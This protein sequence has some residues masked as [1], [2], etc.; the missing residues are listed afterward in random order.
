M[1][2]PTELFIADDFY[3]H[4][5]TNDYVSTIFQTLLTSKTARYLA[6]TRRHLDLTLFETPQLKIF[7]MSPLS[8]P[9]QAC[10]WSLFASKPPVKPT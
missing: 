1:S 10:E 2:S 5:N 4:L 7:A 6:D 9:W 3:V 8:L